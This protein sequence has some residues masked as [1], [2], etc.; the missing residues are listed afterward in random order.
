MVE[1][2]FLLIKVLNGYS[3]V[4]AITSRRNIS[5]TMELLFFS[6]AFKNVIAKILLLIYIKSVK[7][8][9]IIDEVHLPIKLLDQV[10]QV[11]SSCKCWGGTHHPTPPPWI[12]SLQRYRVF[13]ISQDPPPSISECTWNSS[14]GPPGKAIWWFLH[15][16]KRNTGTNSLWPWSKER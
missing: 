13:F 3:W 7:R 1:V 11:T 4:M 2:Y 14:S 6:S 10:T 12:L 16:K 15:F 5:E 9:E 8:K